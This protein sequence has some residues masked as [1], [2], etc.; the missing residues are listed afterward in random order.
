MTRKFM[1][2]AAVVIAVGLFILYNVA[3]MLFQGLQMK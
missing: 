2:W 3:V 1:F